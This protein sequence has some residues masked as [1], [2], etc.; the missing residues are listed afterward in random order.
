MRVE[1][2]MDPEGGTRPSLLG[3]VLRRDACVVYP[4]RLIN[5]SKVSGAGYRRSK[6]AHSDLKKSYYEIW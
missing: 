3:S 6:R 1:G 4:G 2:S 5:R